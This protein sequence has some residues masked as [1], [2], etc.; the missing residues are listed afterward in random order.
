MDTHIAAQAITIDD[1]LIRQRCGWCGELL[2]D[3]DLARLAVPIGQD[4]M[5]AT[6]P[7]GAQVVVN[8]H[9][10]WT[11]EDSDDKLA[12]DSCARRGI[13]ACSCTDSCAVPE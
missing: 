2:L 5:P 11:W 7:P 10:S 6:W 13:A 1:R 8:G 3:Y 12:P 9:A 4:P